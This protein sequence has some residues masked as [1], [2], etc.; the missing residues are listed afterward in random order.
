[1]KVNVKKVHAIQSLFGIK[2]LLCSFKHRNINE[3]LHS[4]DMRLV[5]CKKCQYKMDQQMYCKRNL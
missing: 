1:M 4:H 2:N 5:T 3:Y